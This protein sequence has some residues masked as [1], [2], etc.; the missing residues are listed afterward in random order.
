MREIGTRFASGVCDL[1]IINMLVVRVV[2]FG[3]RV[4]MS[5]KEKV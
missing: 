5:F 4:C 1:V 3:V 2:K